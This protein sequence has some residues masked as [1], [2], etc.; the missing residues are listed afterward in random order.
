MKYTAVVRQELCYDL[1]I[2]QDRHFTLWVVS[3][4]RL[5]TIGVEDDAIL[6]EES[7]DSRSRFLSRGVLHHTKR[8]IDQLPMLLLPSRQHRIRELFFCLVDDRM[9]IGTKEDKIL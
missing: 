7:F 9:A 1:S 2:P 6:A 3:L 5:W 8:F 4:F